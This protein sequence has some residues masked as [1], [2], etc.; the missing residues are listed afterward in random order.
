MRNEYHTNNY[1]TFVFFFMENISY[2]IFISVLNIA[3]LIVAM[4][5][6]RTFPWFHLSILSS[7]VYLIENKMLSFTWYLSTVLYNAICTVPHTPTV[8]AACNCTMTQAYYT[9]P[10]KHTYY[11]NS[12][13][14]LIKSPVNDSE[15]YLRL[16]WFVVGV[17]WDTEL[18]VRA[19]TWRSTVGRRFSS[20]SLMKENEKRTQ[21]NLTE[22]KNRPNRTTTTDT[23]KEL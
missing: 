6:D 10:K 16:V 14:R 12:R 5:H 17:N 20:L 2:L 13:T 9:S 18:I 15:Q 11:T 3:S 23:P 8:Y 7:I 21:T 4:F 22:T 19:H 1:F